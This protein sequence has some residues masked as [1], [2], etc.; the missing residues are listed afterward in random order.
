MTLAATNDGPMARKII[1]FGS[2]P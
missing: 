1:L 2:G